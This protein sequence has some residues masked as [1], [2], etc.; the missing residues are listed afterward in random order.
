MYIF[1]GYYPVT[2]FCHVQNLLC[3]QVLRSPVLAA[4]TARHSSSGR[5]QQFAALYKEW[6]Y[7]IFAECTT[8]IRPGRPSCWASTHILVCQVLNEVNV[9]WPDFQLY[10]TTFLMCMSFSALLIARNFLNTDNKSSFIITLP[11]VAY[12]HLYLLCAMTET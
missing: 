10:T 9:T 4:V 7:G 1:W 5:H 12:N 6:N 3:I 2:E 11:Q 8:C